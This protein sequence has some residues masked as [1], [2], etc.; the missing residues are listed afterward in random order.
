MSDPWPLIY[1]DGPPQARPA[2]ARKIRPT[3]HRPFPGKAGL[4]V[5]PI[6]LNLIEDL[7]LRFDEVAYVDHYRNGVHDEVKIDTFDGRTFNL[8]RYMADYTEGKW[9]I[10]SVERQHQTSS[11]SDGYPYVRSHV[12]QPF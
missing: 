12:S 8:V 7:H 4:L 11:R 9:S 3:P 5:D 6:F 2:N 10:V 1:D